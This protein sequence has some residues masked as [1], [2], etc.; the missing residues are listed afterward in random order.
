MNSLN[1]EITK[2]KKLQ[3]QEINIR[4]YINFSRHFQFFA[5]VSNLVSNNQFSVVIIYI[6]YRA[7]TY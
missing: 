4:K 6:L 2:K 7:I 1:Q 3:E 5:I